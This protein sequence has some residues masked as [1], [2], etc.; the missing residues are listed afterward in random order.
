MITLLWVP[1]GSA[2]GWPIL[3][4]LVI[5]L[6]GVRRSSPSPSTAGSPRT[7]RPAP[8]DRV[9]PGDLDRW[10]ARV[11][12]VALVAPT[13]FPGVW[14]YPILLVGALVA[15][16]ADVARASRRGAPRRPR[17][18]DFRPF[19]AG[20]RRPARAVPRR[21]RMLVAVLV[22]TGSPATEAGIRW[23]LV[24]GLIL[25][26]GPGP[27]SWR[28][29]PRSCSSSPRSSSSRRSI[30]ARSFFGVT[31]VLDRATGDLNVLMNGTTVHGTQSTDPALATIAERPTT[32]RPG[33]S[34]RLRG[35]RRPRGR[36]PPRSASSGSAPARSPLRRARHGDDLLRDRPGRRR[37]RLDR[38]SSRTCRRA[39]PAPAIVLG[40]ARLSLAGEPD[41]RFDL[42]VLD[43]FSRDAVPIHLLTAEAIAD[44][45]RTV[46]PDGVI[47]FHISNRYYDLS[48]AVAARA[49]A[50]GLTLARAIAEVRAGRDDPTRRVPVAGRLAGPGRRSP[51]FALEGW[52]DVHA[53]RPPF[54]DDYAD[55][56]RYLRLGFDQVDRLPSATIRVSGA[57]I[58]RVTSPTLTRSLPVRAGRPR[59]D[60]DRRRAPPDLARRAPPVRR[61][62]AGDLGRLAARNPWATPFSGWAF[63]RAWWDAYGANAHEETLVVVPAD[64]PPARSRS[65]SC[66]SCTAT[67]SSR[68]TR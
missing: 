23:L 41:G 30:P 10:R 31:E 54:T 18:L 17:G 8:P 14:E 6:V 22:V 13:V 61:H 49:R 60:R 63:H 33:R 7:A 37:G 24:G 46:K 53:G 4:I 67:R 47:A 21:R 26:S 2:G 36:R 5:E 57:I 58:R 27:G 40:D 15:L 25:L 29:R 56:L 38:A 50:A 48:P 3:A 12:F 45:L 65:R 1:Y 28:S 9:L 20:F 52:T 66:R 16:A 35:R 64:A 68:A 62:P 32:A 59:P 43:A 44:A 34:G 42:L 55:L 39:R 19:F 11:G 51:T